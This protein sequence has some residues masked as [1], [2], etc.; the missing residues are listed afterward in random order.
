MT[1]ILSDT[2][3]WVWGVLV[4][5][6]ERGVS[7]MTET[8]IT[9]R[10]ALILP[11]VFSIWSI[12]AIRHQFGAGIAAY[13]GLAGST[14]ATLI[15]AWRHFRRTPGLLLERS[16]TTLIRPGTPAVLLLSLCGFAIRYALGV[17]AAREPSLVAMAGYPI[18]YGALSGLA[19][20]A[21]LGMTLGHL[22]GG[23]R[24]SPA[25]SGTMVDRNAAGCW[26]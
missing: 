15:P 9:V 23:L 7:A 21:L 4:F 5:L 26:L 13:A 10:K 1:D 20:G 25:A 11:A 24:A 16:T 3:L 6:L 19:T 2:P 17:T 14:L 18:L 12:V 22:E 8:R